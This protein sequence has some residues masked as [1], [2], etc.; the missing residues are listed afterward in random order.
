MS[1]LTMGLY[2]RLI[3]H[4][5]HTLRTMFLKDVEELMYTMLRTTKQVSYPRMGYAIF[6]ERVEGKKLINAIFKKRDANGR[7]ELIVVAR[8]AEL[9]VNM[10]TKEVR[11]EMHNCEVCSMNPSNGVQGYFPEKTEDMPLPPV[12]NADH[13]PRPRAL[14]CP[15]IMKRRA[16]CVQLENSLREELKVAET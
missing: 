1:A 4:T 8:E 11:V 9:R 10:N 7:P 6:A 14:S 3:P 12:F 15:Q 13:D 5:H 16:E 2:Y